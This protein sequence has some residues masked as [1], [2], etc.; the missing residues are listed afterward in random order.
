[1]N[2]QSKIRLRTC[3]WITGVVVDLDSRG[4]FVSEISEHVSAA[5]L[6]RGMADGPVYIPFC[7]IAGVKT[8]V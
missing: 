7:L 4:L 1:M 6:I 2:A 8:G 5:N 3:G